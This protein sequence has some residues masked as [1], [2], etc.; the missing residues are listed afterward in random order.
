[1]KV[2]KWISASA[3]TGKTTYIVK[4]IAEV[5]QATTNAKSILCIS[6][7]NAAINEMRDKLRQI[8]S[9]EPMFCTIHALGKE[10]IDH[11]NRVIASQSLLEHIATQAIDAVLSNEQWFNLVRAISSDHPS[12]ISEIQSI[13][14][15]ENI[16]SV[17]SGLKSFSHKD[18]SPIAI[19]LSNKAIQELI[20]NGYKELA[21]DMLSQDLE[22]YNTFITHNIKLRQTIINEKFFTKFSKDIVRELKL[23]FHSI[24]QHIKHV[25]DEKFINKTIVLNEFLVNVYQEYVNIKKLFGVQDFNDLISSSMLNPEITSYIKYIYVDEAQDINM[26]QQKF[27]FNL[28]EEVSQHDSFLITIVGDPKQAIYGHTGSSSEMYKN[29]KIS[30]QKF[31]KIMNIM[32][33]EEH[34]SQSKRVPTKVMSFIKNIME[35]NEFDISP[36]DRGAQ[37]DGYV[38]IWE[39][40]PLPIYDSQPCHWNFV[41]KINTPSWMQIFVSKCKELINNG[42]N[43]SNI[44]LL[45]QKRC[46]WLQQ[47]IYLLEENSI[48]ISEYPL[49]IVT[50]NVVYELMMVA[51]LAIDRAHD[52]A[53]SAILKGPFFKL[54]DQELLELCY[55]RTDSLLNTMEKSQLDKI[56]KAYKDVYQLLSFDQDALFFF[57]SVL[58]HTAYGEFLCQYFNNEVN[59]FWEHVMMFSQ[60]GSSLPKFLDYMSSTPNHYCVNADGIKMSTIHNFKGRESEHVFLCNLHV[61][62]IK[63]ILPIITWNNLILYRDKYPLYEDEKLK[64]LSV[65]SKAVNNLLYVAM[66]RTRNGL[67]ILPPPEGVKV[68]HNSLYSRIIDNLS[69]CSNRNYEVVEMASVG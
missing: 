31:S 36:H 21:Q 61:S 51:T 17:K 60:T 57:S 54:S 35:S 29:L 22:R 64:Y 27:L 50:N 43:P 52:G 15:T 40:I 10:I 19:K 11:E 38:K 69:K 2:I 33:V 30:L 37:C 59:I 41:S 23:V 25:T 44:C 47:L 24:I 26:I 8:T 16:S 6:F 62:P 34:L 20:K 1:M 48:P 66:T 12:F 5:L 4:S 18:Q 67:Y 53:L 56:R 42:V 14:M 46:T 28:I 3:G 65:E 32:F 58:F 39:P 55:Q 13:I 45:F 68:F 49:S 63:N 7:T 9:E